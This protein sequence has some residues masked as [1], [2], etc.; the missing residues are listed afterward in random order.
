MVDITNLA[1]MFSQ[2]TGAQPSMANSVMNAVMGF[3]MQKGIGSMFSSGSSG[4]GGIMSAISNVIGGSSNNLSQDHD[5]VKH[6]QQTCGIQDPQQA[7]QYTQQAVSVMNEHG[8]SNPQGLQS[9]LSSLTGG[10]NKDGAATEAVDE[11][12]Q[13]KKKGLLGDVMG[14]LGI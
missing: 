8:K 11:Q 14:G 7:T 1:S 3:M 2:K 9:L 12:D 10:G 4:G 6:V 13:K 5:L